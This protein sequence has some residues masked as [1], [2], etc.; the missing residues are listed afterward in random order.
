M[1]LPPALRRA[2]R[3]IDPDLHGAWTPAFSGIDTE[4]QSSRSATATSSRGWPTVVVIIHGCLV[5]RRGS[6][7]HGFQDCAEGGG[8]RAE[9]RGVDNGAD[10]YFALGRPHGSVA[11]CDLALNN[12]LS[13]GALQDQKLCRPVTART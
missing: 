1:A 2:P 12:G 3:F 8:S 11:V 5:W 7:A 13:Q 10:G 4:H 9:P 6:G